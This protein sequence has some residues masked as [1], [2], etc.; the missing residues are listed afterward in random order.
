MRNNIKLEIQQ[1]RSIATDRP[2]DVVPVG[3]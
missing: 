1:L 2:P 3:M